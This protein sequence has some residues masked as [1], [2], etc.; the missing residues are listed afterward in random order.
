MLCGYL[1]FCD[2]D[3]STL[4]KKILSGQFKIPTFISASAKNLLENILVL[5]PSKRFTIDEIKNHEWFH[6]IEPSKVFG[7]NKD[8]RIVEDVSLVQKVKDLGFN[9]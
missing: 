3:T 7:V 1:P 9:G 5:N 8:E 2:G 4:F 6:Q